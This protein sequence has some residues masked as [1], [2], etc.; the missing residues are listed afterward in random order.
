MSKNLS[1]KAFSFIR[2]REQLPGNTFP[3]G[4]AEMLHSKLSAESSAAGGWSKSVPGK[5]APTIWLQ[6]TEVTE[7]CV[8][9]EESYSLTKILSSLL[10]KGQERNLLQMR[11]LDM[12]Q[13][14]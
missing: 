5:E 1:S 2:A 13:M 6:N 14:I 11:C 3:L 10:E 7:I 12:G 9:V 8:V 4:Y